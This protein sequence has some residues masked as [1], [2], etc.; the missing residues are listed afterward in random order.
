MNPSEASAEIEKV[1]FV[2]I[3]LHLVSGKTMDIPQAGIAWMM[4]TAVMVLQGIERD[5]NNG[6]RYDVVA[7]RNIER[8]EQ[9]TPVE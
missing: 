4:R 3:R 8:I 1:P 9:L 2:P 5:P 6:G 7:L